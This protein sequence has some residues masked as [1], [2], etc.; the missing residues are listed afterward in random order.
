MYKALKLFF[1]TLLIS[2]F[3]F[4]HSAIAKSC[5]EPS[6]NLTTQNDEYYNFDKVVELS[7]EDSKQLKALLK[8]LNRAWKGTSVQIECIGPDQAPEQ[9]VKNIEIKAKTS[10]AS[11]T[12]LTVF[13]DKNN[14]TDRISSADNFTLPNLENTFFLKFKG[15]N[16]LV[17]SEKYRIA[18]T[19]PQVKKEVARSTL[20]TL[21]DK[22]KNKIVTQ[23]KKKPIKRSSSR[24]IETIYEIEINNSS[25]MLLR[26][27]Y[28]NGVFTSEEKWLMQAD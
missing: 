1:T 27:F 17:F 28:T 7:N 9:L 26:S 22:L 5:Y 14:I 11:N 20:S 2:T 23:K 25:L 3:M 15:N 24:L 8:D 13:A 18:N 21:V 4:S 10:L 12:R 16:T 19:K 6:P